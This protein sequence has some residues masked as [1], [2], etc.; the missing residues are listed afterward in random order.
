MLPDFGGSNVKKF[1]I[2]NDNVE[3][4]LT[5][6]PFNKFGIKDLLD[7]QG[8]HIKSLK[9][10]FLDLFRSA[11][12]SI[13]ICSPFFESAGMTQF[14]QILKNKAQDG[15]SIQILTREGYKLKKFRDLKNLHTLFKEHEIQRKLDIRNYHFSDSNN[16]VASSIH[17]KI[18]IVDERL[19]Y[20]GSGE[21]RKNSIEKNLE[22][23]VLLKGE[24]VL[25]LK[26]VFDAIFNVSEMI[27]FNEK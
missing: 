22:L 12:K 3:L 7:G 8:L 16:H 5:L 21:I 15:V 1:E 19:G 25:E 9:K 26:A 4:C 17:A 18:I 24:K 20:L 14:I 2:Q 6:P 11:S 13:C 10:V 23:G 27:K